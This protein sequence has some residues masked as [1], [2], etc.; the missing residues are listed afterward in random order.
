MAMIRTQVAFGPRVPGTPAHEEQLRWMT[1]YLRG[2]ADTV[3]V[4]RFTAKLPSGDTL[5]L[6]NVFA[7]FNP[8]ARDRV[9]LVT[10]WDTRPIA[11]KDTGAA[12][13]KPIPGANDGGSGVAVL[14]QLADVFSRHSPP[15]GVDL[16]FTDGEDYATPDRPEEDMYLGAKHFAANQPP[17]YAPLYGVLVDMVGDQSPR[18]PVEANSASMAPEVVQRVWNVAEEL[19]YGDLF[20][21]EGGLSVTDDHLPLNEAGIRTADVIDLD[22]G[23]GN[24]YWH[25]LQDTPEHTSA[26]GLQAV[27]KVLASLIYRGG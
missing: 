11:D 6:A 1:D 19:G 20:V 18:F 17:G 12:R 7:R 16:L 14:L 5:P 8:D 25:T 22:Y 3:E 4:R 26:R 27:G 23:P 2:R 10:H 13:T 21:K 15:I 24:A 9:L